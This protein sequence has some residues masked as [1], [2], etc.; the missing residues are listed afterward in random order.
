MVHI[1]PPVRMRNA[2]MIRIIYAE[3]RRAIGIEATAGDL[4][5]LAHLIVKSYARELDDLDVFGRPR[6]SKTF[7]SL[8]VDEAM[9]DGGWRILDF[10]VR[11]SFGIDEM[12]SQDLAILEIHIKN[13]LGPQW[14][15]QS[16]T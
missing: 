16:R 6:D 5:R 1:A 11:R 8:P 14:Q 10:E 12:D 4:L 13:F 15:L 7:F 9:K 2:S 3:L